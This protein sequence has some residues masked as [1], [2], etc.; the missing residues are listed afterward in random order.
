METIF[1]Q[2]LNMSIT[3]SWLVLAVIVLRLVFKKAPKAMRCLL[4]A[5]VAIRLLCPFSIESVLSLIPSADPIPQEM[6]YTQMPTIPTGAIV[7]DGETG[8]VIT[9]S[10]SET[11]ANPMPSIPFIASIVWLAG[12]AVML[13]YA[14]ISYLRVRSKVKVAMPTEDDIWICDHISTPFILGII[15]PRI[16]LPSFMGAERDYIIAHEKAHLRRKDHWWKPLGFVLLSVYWFN[17]ILW[18]AYIL[19]CRDIELACDE[20][21][22]KDMDDAD[23]KA[24]TSAL[25][26]SS[27]SH[28]WVA[29][30]PL[31]FGEVGVKSRIKSVLN[32]K[33]PPFWIMLAAVVAAI[34][35]AIGFLTDP[36]ESAETGGEEVSQNSSMTAAVSSQA[37]KDPETSSEAAVLSETT[38]IESESV[39]ESETPSEKPEQSA[40]LDETGA[41]SGSDSVMILRKNDR[42]HVFIVTPTITKI[43]CE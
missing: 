4:W 34:A 39:S 16:Y 38:S 35:V 17:P 9:E 5:L 6:V 19:L 20:K 13:I 10:V 23:K 15:R 3:A 36:I 8:Q 24:Y 28:R 12:V 1:L 27:I 43:F 37:E 40:K 30:S 14:A 32:Y 21:V 11:M 33:K 2:L 7:V 41:E 29:A 42:L 18:I 26:N 31:A 25:L 22:I